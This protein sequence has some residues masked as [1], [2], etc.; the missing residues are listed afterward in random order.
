M[1]VENSKREE[2][3]IYQTRKPDMAAF[4]QAVKKAR[5][6]KGW[7]RDQLAELLDLSPRYIMYIETRGKHPSMKV[8][9]EI[10]VL[11]NISIDQFFFSEVASGKT[12]I[13]RQL[14]AM[15]DGMDH[16]ELVIVTG[17]ANAI[18][19]SRELDLKT[20]GEPVHSAG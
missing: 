4:G 19:K 5:Q 14:D 8:L 18:G 12:T 6:A 13:R 9:Y 20:Q 15:L 17:T 10:A 7:S 3:G 16:R 1:L 11:L 2:N